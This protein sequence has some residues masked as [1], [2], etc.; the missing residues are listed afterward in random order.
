MSQAPTTPVELMWIMAGLNNGLNT[1]ADISVARRDAFLLSLLD[2][3]ADNMPQARNDQGQIMTVDASRG[4]LSIAEAC[5][6]VQE[7]MRRLTWLLKDTYYRDI[8][9]PM[10]TPGTEMGKRFRSLSA[11]QASRQ[12]PPADDVAEELCNLAIFCG[13]KM[14]KL[15]S[16]VAT[17]FKKAL[18]SLQIDYEEEMARIRFAWSRDPLRDLLSDPN[19]LGNLAD[20]H[21]DER[22]QMS[23]PADQNRWIW[24]PRF[25]T[26]F[27]S[28]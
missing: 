25:P 9:S 16:Q 22:T 6:A 1:E 10:H 13:T 21:L 20:C 7:Y 23:F 11:S 4:L 2:F 15:K 14:P 8:I 12:I 17:D 26:T 18:Q 28:I 24:I 5:C 3:A 27:P 19:C